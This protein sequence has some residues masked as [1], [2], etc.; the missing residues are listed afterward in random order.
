LELVEDVRSRFRPLPLW[1]DHDLTAG[2]RLPLEREQAN[3]LLNVLRLKTDDTVLV[4]NGRDGEWLAAIT[5]EGRKA[6]QPRLV[7]QVRAQP[8]R[9][10]CIICSRR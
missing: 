6:G 4:F 5:S 1:V 2:T 10:I 3:Y 7:R 8:Q 9:P